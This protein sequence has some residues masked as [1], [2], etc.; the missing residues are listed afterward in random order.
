MKKPT[1]KQKAK[2]ELISLIMSYALSE[3]NISYFIYD[4]DRELRSIYLIR[5]KLKMEVIIG[6]RT[7][8]ENK[9]LKFPTKEVLTVIKELRNKFPYVPK[10]D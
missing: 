5:D 3:E 10:K 9:L 7:E 8:L 1:K 2:S 6:Q 4:L